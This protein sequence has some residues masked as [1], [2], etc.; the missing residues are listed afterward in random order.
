MP[1]LKVQ[2]PHPGTQKPFKLGNGYRNVNGTI[3]REWNNDIGHYRKFLLNKGLYLDN[4]NDNNP[5]KNDLFLWGEWEGN[6]FFNPINNPDYRILPNGVHKPFHSIVIR[7]GQNTDPYVY[8]NNF[9]YCVCKQTG[10]MCNLS[11]GSLILFGSVFPKLEKFYIDTV[12]VVKDHNTAAHINTTGASGFSQ[13]YRE[14]TLEQLKEYLGTPYEPTN[15]KLYKS[16]TWWD[17]NEYFSF[18]PCKLNHDGNGFERLYLSLLKNPFL[19]PSPRGKSF[20][21]NYNSTPEQLWLDIVKIAKE[22]GFKLGIQ[23]EE[24]RSSNILDELNV[25]HDPPVTCDH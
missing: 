4:K 1:K 12:F 24:P 2:F 19:S 21:R 16:Q 7:G 9:K 25:R 13:T 18:V 11:Q 6:S 8:G 15:K 10:N 20:L 23:F 22:Q 3:I 17:N 5:K 14:V